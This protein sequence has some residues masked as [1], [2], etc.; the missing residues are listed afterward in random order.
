TPSRA[1]EKAITYEI[2]RHTEALRTGERI[3][4]ETR[5]W[6]ADREETRSM[7]RKEYADD[8]RYF[9]E[10]DLLP[11][12]VEPAWVEEVRAALPEMPA[13]KRRRFVAEY[14]LPDYD[15]GVL[16]LSRNVADYYEAVARESGNAKAASNWV[17]TEDL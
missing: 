2:A 6:D 5:L 13:E 15:A 14:G 9:P 10:P 8:Y 1:G 4:Q 12:V 16:T 7:R 3:V 17:M 11:L